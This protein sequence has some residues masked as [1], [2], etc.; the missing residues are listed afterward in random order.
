MSLTKFDNIIRSALWTSYN[1]NCFYCTKPLDWDD[2]Q[3]D[4]IIPESLTTN[5]GR[6]C[7]IISEYELDNDFSINALCNLVSSHS[8]CNQR[9]GDELF[10]KQTTLFYLG[11]TNKSIDK[12]EIEITKLKNRRNKGQILSKLQSALASNLIDPNELEKILKNA[13]IQN[14]NLAKIKL[15]M[16]VQFLDEVYDSFYLNTDCSLLYDRKLLVGDI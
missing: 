10:N 4:H 12:I 13:K 5:P 6:L 7:K 3:I 11:L 9:K 14:W 16:G 2:L 15:P 8:K 1:Y